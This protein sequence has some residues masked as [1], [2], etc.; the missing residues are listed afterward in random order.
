MMLVFAAG[1]IWEVRRLYQ[2]RA[3]QLA[4][5]YEM[6]RRR[7]IELER[8]D[9]SRHELFSILTHELLHPVA[10]IRAL[11]VTLTSRWDTTPEET[12]LRLASRVEAESRRLRELAEEA[13][14]VTSLDGEG[15]TLVRRPEPALELAREAAEMVDDL[16]GR[17]KVTVEPG[18]ESIRVDADRARI[19]QA[20]R[21]L[22]SNAEK[23]SDEGT[24]IELALTGGDGQ[25]TFSV[26]NLGPGIS[27]EDL[28][29]L[30]QKFSRT[31]PPGKEGVPGSGLGLYISK[32][33]VEFHGGRIW[34]ESWP[35]LE[36]TFSFDLPAMG[37]STLASVESNA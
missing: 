29:S 30:F 27:T 18:T 7:V 8:L 22:L 13:T 33:I 28:P 32:R 25:V 15:F 6:E 19:L 4:A 21:N 34:V 16:G 1:L 24:P 3:E 2:E 14:T 35:G 36:T 12:R 31:R 10:T 37:S 9:R 23:Y 26:K 20:L 17:L 11:A 5:A